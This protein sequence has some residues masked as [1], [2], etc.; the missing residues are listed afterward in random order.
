MSLENPISSNII[1]PTQAAEMLRVSKPTVYGYLRSK[2]IPSHR[3]G[4]RIFIEI[5]SL[6]QARQPRPKAGDGYV[7]VKKL[8]EL[9]AMP[10][11]TAYYKVQCE[12]IPSI[13]A[14][15]QRFIHRKTVDALLARKTKRIANSA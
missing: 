1:T 3:I 4:G 13:R 8:A 11:P 10:L 7:S 14:G 12:E 5:G 2:Q 15:G 9:L 6:M